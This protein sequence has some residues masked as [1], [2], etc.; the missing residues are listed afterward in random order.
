MCLS[1][2]EEIQGTVLKEKQKKKKKKKKKS[3]F[4]TCNNIK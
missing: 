2:I 3:N 4:N 1:L